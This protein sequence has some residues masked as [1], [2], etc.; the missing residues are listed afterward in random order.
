MTAVVILLSFGKLGTIEPFR[1][2]LA[3]LQ[4]RGF[5]DA[6]IGNVTIGHLWFI[7][8]ILLCYL[9]TP[10][11]QFLRE[12]IN[13][14]KAIVIVFFLSI[15]E[16]PFIIL[17]KPQGFISCFPGVFSYILAYF[18]GAYWNKIITKKAYIILISAMIISVITRLLGKHLADTN[19][20]EPVIYDK[21]I[22]N[23]THC[24]LAFWIFL[25]IYY[26]LT[27]FKR[28]GDLLYP[29]CKVCDT[30]SYEVYIF[31]YM[32]ITGVLSLRTLTSNIAINIL[33]FAIMTCISAL[34][35]HYTAAILNKKLCSKK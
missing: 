18:L 17:I 24:V 27:N 10:F 35:L 29:I 28:L 5:V 7:S 8:F 15:V 16:M 6:S 1:C 2:I 9:I 32:Y 34:F 23:Y 31:H 25:T 12:R 14:G 13:L 21:V 30:Y 20:I 22:A 11:L 3:I 33:L 26:L 19:R 4:L